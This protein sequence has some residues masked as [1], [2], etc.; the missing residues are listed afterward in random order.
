MPDMRVDF[1]P[2]SRVAGGLAFHT[3]V[4]LE[5]GEVLEAGSMATIWRQSSE[6]IDPPAPV[7]RT[8]FP[9]R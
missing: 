3:T 2:V 7:T 8:T 5:Q 4:D 1:N 6:P 9:V